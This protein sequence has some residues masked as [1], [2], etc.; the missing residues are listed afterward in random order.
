MGVRREEEKK[1]REGGQGRETDY[2]FKQT[3]IKD[4]STHGLIEVTDTVKMSILPKATSKC[5]TVS[6]KIPMVPFQK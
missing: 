5:Y 6:I 3:E 1:G 4:T 2:E